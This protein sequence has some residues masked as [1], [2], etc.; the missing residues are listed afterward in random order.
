LEFV[1][2]KAGMDIWLEVGGRMLEGGS[3]MSD[4]GS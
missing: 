3:Q 1:V 4:A 2:I